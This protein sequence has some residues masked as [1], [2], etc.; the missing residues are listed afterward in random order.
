[1]QITKE[2]INS[3]EIRLSLTIS[4]LKTILLV[5]LISFTSLLIRQ[6]L[7]IQHSCNPMIHWSGELPKECQIATTDN[8]NLSDRDKSP[9]AKQT[10]NKQNT[11]NSKSNSRDSHDKTVS[12]PETQLNSAPNQITYGPPP[13]VENLQHDT[14]TESK[15]I[16][17]K[18]SETV[19]EIA[20][21]HPVEVAAVS[22][23][24]GAALTVAAWPLI[25]IPVAIAGVGVAIFSSIFH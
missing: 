1:M 25:G 11:N 16:F 12:E 2:I 8:L 18:V 5:C 15:N 19:I 14:E 17:E 23:V 7:Q 22:L 21:E 20:E 24:V 9:L 13:T 3:S 4:K 6:T 10:D